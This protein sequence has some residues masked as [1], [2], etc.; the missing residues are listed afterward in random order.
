M[1]AR[2]VLHHAHRVVNKDGCSV[3]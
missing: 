1:N 2:D 3:W